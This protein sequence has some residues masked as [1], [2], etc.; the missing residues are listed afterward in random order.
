MGT[1]SLR[2]ILA[3]GTSASLA[4]MTG[5][6]ALGAPQYGPGV[7]DTEIRIGQTMPY[8]AAIGARGDDR[9]DDADLFR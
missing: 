2:R 3:V 6:A 7:T 4:L 5:L 9:E 8:R 1:R